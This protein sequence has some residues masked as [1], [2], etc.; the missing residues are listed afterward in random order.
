MLFF[1]IIVAKLRVLQPLPKSPARKKINGILFE[2]DSNYDSAI[3]LMHSGSYEVLTLE[4]I[5]KYLNK[6]DTFIDVGANIGWFSAIALGLVGKNGQVHSF[7]PVPQ[8]FYRLQEMG[9]FNREYN[10]S[11]N[12][13]ALGEGGGGDGYYQ[14]IQ[15]RLGY[16]GA[17]PYE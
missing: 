5:R 2:F 10:I 15:H 3:K 13:C 1:K 7:E 11:V 14:L 17:R 16:H 6:G 4:A 12:Q 9:S 8:N